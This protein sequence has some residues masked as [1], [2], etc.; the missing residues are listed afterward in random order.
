MLRYKADARTLAF[1]TSLFGLMAL[2]WTWPPAWPLRIAL[3]VAIGCMSFFC[4]V[5]THNTVHAPVFQQRWLNR[6][7]QVVLTLTYGH[8]VS[9]FVPG[10][11]MSHHVH[12]QTRKDIM[13]TTKARFRWNLL[14]QL[15]FA[16]IVS[17]AISK[18]E[19]QYASAMRKERPRWFRQLILETVALVVFYATLLVLDWQKAILYVWIP[20]VHAAWG[21]VGIN[22]VQ[23]DGCDT[24]SKVNHS[25]NFMSPILNWWTFNNGYHGMHHI[26]PGLHW[27]L[28]P[29]MHQSILAPTIHP[30]LEQRSLV[31]YLWRAYIWPGKRV[32]YLG[33]PVVLPDEGPDEAWIPGIMDTPAEVSL[34]AIHS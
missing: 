13:R 33:R 10:H 12:T 32:D 31:A 6:I 29:Q 16:A 3:I 28:L 15:F 24:S 20:H 34:G 25:R 18:A 8:P 23:H 27:S 21:V 11:N 26:K 17:G 2:A 7:F 4:A 5:I 14:N 30:N 22:F 1:V 19:W 9:S